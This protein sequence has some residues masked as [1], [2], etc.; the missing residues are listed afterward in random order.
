MKGFPLSYGEIAK[1]R[2]AM[3]D[4]VFFV[5][6]EG[7]G[8]QVYVNRNMDDADMLRLMKKAVAYLEGGGATGLPV[9]PEDEDL[10]TVRKLV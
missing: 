1:L 9:T 6:S 3:G 5:I 10:E 7:I 8:D 4:R 2:E